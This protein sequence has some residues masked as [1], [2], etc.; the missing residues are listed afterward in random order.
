MS[1]TIRIW[2]SKAGEPP[3]TVVGIATA[4]VSSRAWLSATP[5]GSLGRLRLSRPRLCVGRPNGYSEACGR[6]ALV[7]TT[8]DE[9]K[10]AVLEYGAA[11]PGE[12]ATVMADKLR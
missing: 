6:T 8:K 5:S 7:G 2:P 12:A 11:E 10:S 9:H 1:S 4:P 3:M